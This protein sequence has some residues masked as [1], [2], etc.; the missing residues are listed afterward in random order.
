M[1]QVSVTP[2]TLSAGQRCVLTIKLANAG[3]DTYSAV[4]FRLKLPPGMALVSGPDKIVVDQIQARQT[5]VHQVTVL[6]RRLGDVELSTPNFSY[7]DEDGVTRR[8][9]DWRA[10]IRVL[11]TLP[12]PPQPAPVSPVQVGAATS[13]RLILSHS[14]GKL[15]LGKWGDLELSVRNATGTSVHDVLLTVAG[16]FQVDH[17]SARIDHLRD[18][19]TDCAA[20]SVHIPDRGK[21]PVRIRTTYRYWDERGQ[22]VPSAQNDR[23]TI[24]ATAPVEPDPA[25]AGKAPA[26]TILFLVAQPRNTD[27]LRSY[28]EMREVEM[29]LRLGRDQARYRLK[30][31]VATRLRDISQALGDYEP[32][33]VHFAGH[34]GDDGSLVVEDDFGRASSANPDGLANLLGG[35]ASV[36]CV[37]VNACH[38]L[39]LA[40]AMNKNI[41][42]VVG[43]GSEIRDTVS[44][45]FSVGFYQGLFAG[46]T[47]PEAF[48]Q[49]RDL[50]QAEPKTNSSYQVP[51]LLVRET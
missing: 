43:M 7:R 24:E 48:R 6:P 16:P 50:V 35:F 8:Q 20:I 5:H 29:L 44:I 41:D 51:I 40:K 23:L 28:A 34:G 26:T 14:G 4:V 33:I 21:I 30:R 1:I 17:P 38:S 49:G 27:H 9:D 42:Y 22:L 47:V 45:Q 36:R 46:K 15:A 25:P 18:G 10:P 13:P 32:Q 3:L 2:A 31:H 19:A 12:P 37:I 11:A 39:V